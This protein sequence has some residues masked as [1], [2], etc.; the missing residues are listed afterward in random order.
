MRVCVCA[1][2]RA[3][4]CVCMHALTSLSCTHAVEQHISP[5]PLNPYLCCLPL[6]VLLLLLLALQLVEQHVIDDVFSL[7]F[8][9]PSEGVMLLGEVGGAGGQGGRCC[10]VGSNQPTNQST[11]QLPHQP[12]INQ[13]VYRHP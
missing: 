8:G 4:V 6:C 3:P 9:H 13:P 12:S 11:N 7:C 10:L 5:S 2:V 1:C